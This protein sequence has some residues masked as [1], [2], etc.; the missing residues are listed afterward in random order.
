[1]AFLEAFASVMLLLHLCASYSESVLFTSENSTLVV[2]CEEQ[3][4]LMVA[5][6]A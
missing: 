2:I 5:L 3:M 4:H 6:T 1:M